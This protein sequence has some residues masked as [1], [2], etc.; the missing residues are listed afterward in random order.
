MIE[1]SNICQPLPPGGVPLVNTL[2]SRLSTHIHKYASPNISLYLCCSF[3]FLVQ[4]EVTLRPTV[5]RPVR[6]GVRR[7]SGTRDQFYF[8]LE[9]FFRQLRVC[10]FVAPSLTKGRVCN[11]LYNYFF[12]T[13]VPHYIYIAGTD[14]RENASSIIPC[15]L[16]AGE[17]TC[18]QSY[19]LATTIVPSCCFGMYLHVAVH[20]WI[21]PTHSQSGQPCCGTHTRRWSV[22]LCLW[23]NTDNKCEKGLDCVATV[24]RVHIPT[25]L[26][27]SVRV[28]WKDTIYSTIKH[29]LN[30]V[31]QKYRVDPLIGVR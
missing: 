16:V 25:L 20:C 9:I 26:S 7:P 23:I 10:N 28:K 11:L 14:H 12:P 17:T 21:G 8:L 3:F 4:V 15:Y 29:K 18:P 5:S 24:P 31:M 22:R 27:N 2:P 19:S 30:P 13:L 6:L 1:V